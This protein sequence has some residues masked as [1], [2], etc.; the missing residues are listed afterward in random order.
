MTDSQK[1]L[2]YRCLFLCL[3][4]LAV[5][6]NSLGNGF[7]W[8]DADIIADN[9]ML[10][11]LGNIPRFFLSEDRIESATGY[12]RPMTYVS[13]AVDRAVWGLNPVGFNITN[14]LLQMAA[15]LLFYRVVAALFKNERL[16]FAAA[17][18]F[19]LHPIA[20]ETVNFHAGGRNTLLCACFG[21]L[22]LLFYI[23]KR[24][25]PAVFC[26]TLAI[27]S[28]EFALLLPAVFFLYD[29][30]IVREK[31]SWLQYLYYA[32]SIIAYLT[33]R[34]FAVQNANF[35]KTINFA[36]SLL[37][38]PYIVTKY[39][40]A[41]VYPFGVKVLYD[42]DS[43]PALY[44]RLSSLLLLIAIASAAVYFRK[45]RET[46]FSAC[47]FFLFMLPVANII[48]LGDTVMADRYAYF[49]LMGFSLALAYAISK[50]TSRVAVALLIGICV[51][52]ALV[53]FQRNRIWK[54]NFSF[55]TQMTKDAPEL[56]IG[57]QNLGV[58]HLIKGDTGKAQKYL[59]EAYPKKG[60]SIKVV[61]QLLAIY[62]ETNRLDEAL[63]L[64]NKEMAR[65]P[66]NLHAF[67]MVSSV[68]QIMGDKVQA[69]RYYDKALALFPGLEKVMDQRA[70]TLCLR[71][72]KLL[73]QRRY[74]E[75]RTF[76]IEALLMKPNYVPTLLDLGSLYAEKGNLTVAERYFSKAVALEP[77]N[78]SAHY[79][80]S[81]AY[82]LMGRPADARSEMGTF[83]E[84]EARSKKS[85]VP[86]LQ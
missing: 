31:K 40:F 16:A 14:L 77:L 66:N 70:T 86:A 37:M 13:F 41:M 47:W 10:K 54:D 80:L 58:Y 34:S 3:L 7:V 42:I 36:D 27:F 44:L 43:S 24:H 85:A 29:K 60:A 6:G 15:A 28:K 48:P 78:P 32:P 12:Y 81:L 2:I 39:L 68:Y 46:G 62:L 72:E 33:L 63:T 4:I 82:D 75:A 17:L 21:L 53:D 69:K 83:R 76:L 18:L 65:E 71:G 61:Q 5:Y 22:S 56:S 57:F 20:G 11:Q 35:L 59:A 38:A 67:V 26:F 74:F 84:L 45:E 55:F 50:A 49:S 9:P 51:C 25:I 64:L 73:A 52:F 23:N 30:Y 1:S 8:D 19:S 79:N